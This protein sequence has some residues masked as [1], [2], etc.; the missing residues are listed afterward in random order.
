MHGKHVRKH[1]GYNFFC[2]LKFVIF[3]CNV[4]RAPVAPLLRYAIVVFSLVIMALIV[5][6]SGL[7]FVS[8][9]SAFARAVRCLHSYLLIL[10]L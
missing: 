2:S 3:G 4:W 6:I 7:Q 5:C 10:C 1:S 8:V 9:H